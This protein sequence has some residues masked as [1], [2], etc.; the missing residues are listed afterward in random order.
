MDSRIGVHKEAEFVLSTRTTSMVDASVLGF[1]EMELERD[2]E[3]QV[4]FSLRIE[5]LD[6]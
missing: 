2:T 3:W 5:I 6:E 4:A 1:S